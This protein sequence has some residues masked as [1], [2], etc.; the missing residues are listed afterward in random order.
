MSIKAKAELLVEL[1]DEE[2]VEDCFLFVF[3]SLKSLS[4][5]TSLM[6]TKVKDKAIK[7]N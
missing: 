2:F 5:C 7:N 4:A 1:T 6:T 3:T